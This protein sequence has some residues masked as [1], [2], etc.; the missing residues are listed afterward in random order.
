MDLSSSRKHCL[1][2]NQKTSRQETSDRQSATFLEMLS[3]L[4]DGAFNQD[5]DMLDGGIE[6][7][8]NC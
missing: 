5:S 7:H 1:S 4:T 2:A 6:K 8:T 3:G